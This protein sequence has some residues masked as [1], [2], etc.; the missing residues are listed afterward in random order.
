MFEQA[1]KNIDDVL[2]K[3]AGCTTELDYTEQTSWLLFLKY[4]D[5]LDE[6][7]STE[8]ALDGKKY[9]HILDKPYRWESWAAPKDKS[10]KLDHNK[11]LIG[12]DLCD[13]VNVKLFPYLQ[14]FKLKA[15]GPNTIEYKIGEIFSEIKN[16]IQSGYNLRLS[17]SELRGLEWGDYDPDA[18]VIHVERKMW[19][20]TVGQPKTEKRKGSVPVIPHL[21][22]YL[23]EHRQ[24]TGWILA[25]EL[26]K[27]LNL[28]WLTK[29]VV[30]PAVKTAGI[31]WRGWHAFRRGLAT[32]LDRLGIADTVIQAILRHSSVTVTRQSYIK[33]VR[34]DVVAAMGRLEQALPTYRHSKA[35]PLRLPPL[36]PMPPRGEMN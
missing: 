16:R 32:N 25:D 27:P 24:D 6:D 23:D 14:G 13:F 28:D 31:T 17:L 9:T 35:V 22:Q 11:V 4:L 20:D 36:P 5:D 12:D 8:A 1:F 15:S 3:E 10:G 18:K 30:Q 2:R 7:K 34:E 33:E 21:A 26:G 29:S 19:H